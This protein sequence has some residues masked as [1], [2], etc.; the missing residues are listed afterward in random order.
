MVKKN[1]LCLNFENIL[2][3]FILHLILTSTIGVSGSGDSLCVK[4]ERSLTFDGKQP[5]GNL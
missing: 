1:V 3:K 4:C 2:G 5:S